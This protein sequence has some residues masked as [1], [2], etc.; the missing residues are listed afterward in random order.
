L[1]SGF[2][3]DGLFLFGVKVSHNAFGIFYR[4]GCRAEFRL[5][6]IIVCGIV[7]ASYI[8]SLFGGVAVPSAF[9]FVRPGDYRFQQH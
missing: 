2:G 9:L 4:Q 1:H 8:K 3:H 7:Y 5:G 6:N